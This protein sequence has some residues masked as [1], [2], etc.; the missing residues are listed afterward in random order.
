MIKLKLY[1][2]MVSN[3]MKAKTKD[4]L[5][6]AMWKPYYE[7][8]SKCASNCGKGLKIILLNAPC[9]GF[10]DLIFALKLSNYLKEWYSADVTLATTL[11]KG[12]LE[13]GA[14]P[15]HTVGLIGGNNKLQCRRF[16]RLKLNREIPQQDLILIAPMQID[17]SPDLAD[18]KALLPYA[19]VL[20]TFSFSEYNDSL[21]KKF[22]FNTG[23][24]KNRDGILLTKYAKG[25]GLPDGLKNPYALIYVAGSLPDVDICILSF[26][27]MIA[28]KYYKKYKKL[29]I[30]IPDWFAHQNLN[31]R[32][33]HN[34]SKY[35]P[36]ILQ[37]T[38]KKLSNERDSFV[39]SEGH[40]NENQ[41]TF[42]CDILPVPNKLMMHLMEK[43]I[44]DILLTGDQSIT[45]AVSCCYK[46]NIFYQIAPWKSDLAKNL[47]KEMPNSFLKTTQTSCGS[48]KAINYDSKYEKFRKTWDFRSRS[49]PKM[50]A[51]ILSILAIK[52]DEKLST[53]LDCIGTGT[54]KTIKNKV[55]PIPIIRSSRKRRSSIS[56][57][58]SGNRKRRSSI[59]SRKRK[60]S[61]SRRNSGNRKRRSSIS[62][63]KRKSSISSR[64]RKSSISRRNSGNRKRRSSISS[65]KRK[66]S[67]SRRNSGNRKR[68]RKSSISR[69]NSGNRK[70]RSS[71]LE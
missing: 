70:R 5:S 42:R 12:L 30:V 22:T 23:V 59:S 47:T 53:I 35:Y 24:G 19:N 40:K 44:N 41:L 17:F 39:I 6:D 9:N 63:R 32:L 27:E 11:E 28:K 43:S 60:S 56:R 25:S 66:S 48:L 67:I 7:I 49:K 13:L 26:V 38:K 37:I 52:N 21:D 4:D 2:K 58:N 50:D 8:G 65:R 3:I 68:K 57:R 29:D 18:V 36:N 16:K 34:V 61:I 33:V 31:D 62:S 64:K 45:D 15:K 14:D 71:K 51:I 1:E 69:R 20:N 55:N 10:G 54:L 46:K